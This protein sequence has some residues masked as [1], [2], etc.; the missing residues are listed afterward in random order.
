MTAILGDVLFPNPSDRD[1]PAC[2]N[3]D[4]VAEDLLAFEDAL[5]VVAH[6]TVS[7]ITV[8]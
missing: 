1:D 8:P 7:P 5:G 6:G 4:R 3:G 2:G